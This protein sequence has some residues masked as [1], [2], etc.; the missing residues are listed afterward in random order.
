M[1]KQEE[2][3]KKVNHDPIKD[4]D[5]IEECF[6]ITPIGAFGSDVYNK[7]MGLIDAVINP[8]LRERKME[9]M[10]ANRMQDLGS[11]NKQLIRRVI[12]DR[13]VIANLTGLN[14]NVMYELAVRH[15]ARKP[16]IIMAEEGTR[17]PFDISDQRTIFYSD[18]LSGVETA[19]IELRK[20]I[21]Y[22]L[23]DESPDNPIYSYL[24]NAELFKK[25]A[26]SDFN[27]SILNLLV[28]LDE[29]VSASN[30]NH[31]RRSFDGRKAIL[32][33]TF[34]DQ[35]WKG[36]VVDSVYRYVTIHV[37]ESSNAIISLNDI[38]VRVKSLLNHYFIDNPPKFTATADGLNFEI[39]ETTDD[40]TIKLLVES[41]SKQP[42]V[43]KVIVSPFLIEK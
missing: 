29:K 43:D 19:K 35:P 23:Q 13:L 17:L 31:S 7:A 39:P 28:S 11:I 27:Q 36:N 37:D 5:I 24:E 20:K 12:E 38:M 41:I 1:A 22:A 30:T 16:V 40:L 8:V 10:T 18:T 42:G 6:I 3:R 2:K 33:G 14:A 4:N 26:D 25:V 9:A 15:A 34:S 32:T 21:T